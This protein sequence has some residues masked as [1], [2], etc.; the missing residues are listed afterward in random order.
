MS[1]CGGHILVFCLCGKDMCR[2]HITKRYGLQWIIHH[3]HGLYIDN[4]NN[5][6]IFTFSCKNG[7]FITKYTII[8][9]YY[10][11]VGDSLHFDSKHL[12]PGSPYLFHPHLTL[13]IPFLPQNQFG[14]QFGKPLIFLAF[15]PSSHSLKSQK[16]H[17]KPQ[18]TPKNQHFP[19]LTKKSRL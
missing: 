19:E 1:L 10:G 8:L 3:K 9:Y 6:N 11:I 7:L 14:K 18:K 5:E 16:N 2:T 15:L 4:T 12:L 17:S 13:K